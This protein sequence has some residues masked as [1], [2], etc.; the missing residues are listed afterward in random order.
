MGVGLVVWMAG[1]Q[2]S[3]VGLVFSRSWVSGLGSL[4]WVL[5]L[6]FQFLL[7]FAVVIVVLSLL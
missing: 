7:C 4:D 1:G 2:G 3:L 6:W 5:G